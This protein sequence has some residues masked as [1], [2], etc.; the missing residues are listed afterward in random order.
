MRRI[1]T[2][3]LLAVIFSITLFPSTA[4]AQT[5]DKEGKAWLEKCSDPSTLNVN[6]D[7]RD[8][9]WYSK[10]N[11]HNTSWNNVTLSQQQD[12]R[13]ITGWADK[14]DIT[15]VVSGNSVC[16]LFSYEG[17]IRYSAKLTARLAENIPLELVGGYVKGL[18]SDKSKTTPMR[19]VRGK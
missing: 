13:Q 14:W 12:S 19:L 10:S 9:D 8:A 4:S 6:G 7:W 18:L 3:S 16:L 11:W 1:L 2:R 15:G 17:R 5:V